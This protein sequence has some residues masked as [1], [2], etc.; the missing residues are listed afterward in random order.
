M[1]T[2]IAT[3][4]ISTAFFLAQAAGLAHSVRGGFA[5]SGSGFGGSSSGYYSYHGSPSQPVRS[6]PSVARADL[7]L[8]PLNSSGPSYSRSYSSPGFI[9][10]GISNS[11]YYFW[12]SDP[13][14]W[15]GGRTT[16]K[17]WDPPRQFNPPRRYYP[18]ESYTESPPAQQTLYSQ[19][20]QRPRAEEAIELTMVKMDETLVQLHA[21]NRIGSFDLDQYSGELLRI[22]R[23]YAVMKEAKGRLS[24]RQTEELRKEI[25]TLKSSLMRQTALASASGG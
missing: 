8:P 6:D 13:F 22:K 16:I 14:F 9:Q 19:F 17:N 12:N 23:N 4:T 24:E 15:P 2:L 10:G 21:Q 20:P 1:K 11:N 18:A 3:L 25:A 7:G 5:N